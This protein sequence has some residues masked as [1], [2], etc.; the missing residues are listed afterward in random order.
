MIAMN[1]IVMNIIVM[2]IIV[3]NNI[4]YKI[5]LFFFNKNKNKRH[6]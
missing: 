3:M 2:N 6:T 5:D 4:L 1:M